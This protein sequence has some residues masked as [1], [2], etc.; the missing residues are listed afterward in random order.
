MLLR[1]F[2]LGSPKAHLCVIRVATSRTPADI[3]VHPKSM[4]RYTSAH[5]LIGKRNPS[6]TDS[7]A[8]HLNT[9]SKLSVGAGA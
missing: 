2:Q 6:P 9:D 5:T 8:H 1:D 3:L 4:I 7:C